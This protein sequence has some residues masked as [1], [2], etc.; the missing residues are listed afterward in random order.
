MG[1]PTAC[2][3]TRGSWSSIT[4]GVDS[5]YYG[6]GSA[7]TSAPPD[8]MTL[9]WLAGLP[10]MGIMPVGLGQLFFIGD[11]NGIERVP[12]PF[13]DNLFGFMLNDTLAAGQLTLMAEELIDFIE[14]PP[15]E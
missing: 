6:G 13:V 11:V 14:A 5:I 15:I 10:P 12:Q 4:E 3:A 8:F 9:G 7:V 2:E 1:G